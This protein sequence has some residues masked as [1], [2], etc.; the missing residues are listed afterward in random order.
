MTQFAPGPVARHQQRLAQRR[1]S[2]IKQLN[3]TPPVPCDL[4][5]GQTVSYT[6]EY[7]VTFPGHTI[8]GFSATDSFYGRFIHLDTDCYWMPKHP[9]SVTPE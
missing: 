4:K 2:F 3:T 5:V 6:N 7:G 9:A 1:E 8:V